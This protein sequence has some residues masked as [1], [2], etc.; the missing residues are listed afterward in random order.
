MADGVIQIKNTDG[1]PLADL[2]VALGL[3]DEDGRV[4]LDWFTDP[5]GHTR[6]VFDTQARREALERALK[7]LMGLATGVIDEAVGALQLPRLGEGEDA[8]DLGVSL[9]V[10]GSTEGGVAG[11]DIGL[12]GAWDIP[13]A[14]STPRA[15][16]DVFVRLIRVQPDGISAEA[17]VSLTATL[18]LPADAPLGGIGLAAMITDEGAAEASLRFIDVEVAQGETRTVE[19]TF[20]AQTN[21]QS[22]ERSLIELALAFVQALIHKLEIPALAV[23]SDHLFQLLGWAEPGVGFGPRLPALDLEDLFTDPLA[24]FQRWLTAV[25][26]AGEDSLKALLKHLC[27]LLLANTG[28][29]VVER[30]GDRIVAYLASMTS[31]RVELVLWTVTDP[32][33][34]QYLHVGLRAL[35]REQL[36]GQRRLDFV[37]SLDVFRIHLTGAPQI[38]PVGALEVA[39]ALTPVASD[40]K[41][42]HLTAADIEGEALDFLAPIDIRAARAGFG[43]TPDGVFRPFVEL[44]GVAVGTR[45]WERLDLTNLDAVIEAAGDAASELVAQAI[46]QALGM[47]EDG[48]SWASEAGRH[49]AVLL[50]LIDPVGQ[51]GFPEIGLAPLLGDPVGG[52]RRFIAD[53]IADRQDPADPRWFGTWLAELRLLINALAGDA[54][55]LAAITGDGQEAT[56][57]RLTLVSGT[58]ATFSLCAWVHPHADGRRALNLELCLDP[59]PIVLSPSTKTL[60]TLLVVG[61]L[62]LTAPATPGGP[63]DV[64]PLQGARVD[65]RLGETLQIT[66]LPNLVAVRALRITAGATW[67]R[68]DDPVPSLK[69]IN[70]EIVALGGLSG[71]DLSIP[72]LPA[73]DLAGLDFKLPDLGALHLPLFKLLFRL[74]GLSLPGWGSGDGS[75]WGSCGMGLAQLLVGWPHLNL[76]QGS[77]LN[78]SVDWPTL[79][80]PAIDWPDIDLSLDD[81]RLFLRNPFEGLLA[82][83]GRLFL[84][85]RVGPLQLPGLSFLWRWLRGVFPNA[86]GALPS[87]ALPPVYGDGTY[88]RPWAIRVTDDQALADGA[89]RPIELLVWID[90]DGPSLTG[91]TN[92]L[93]ALIPSN[94]LQQAGDQG[95][96]ALHRA[97]VAVG[98]YIPQLADATRGLSATAFAQAIGAIEAL[99]SQGATLA[100]ARAAAEGLRLLQRLLPEIDTN[101]AADAVIG[102]LRSLRA[103][104]DAQVT[105]G[106]LEAGAVA[107]QA[108]AVVSALSGASLSAWLIGQLR[109]RLAAWVSALVPG[110]SR[111]APTHLG[112]GLRTALSSAAATPIGQV[113]LDM[114]ARFDLCSV[115]LPGAPNTPPEHP[116][117][118]VHVTGAVRRVD[119]WLLGDAAS[120]TR[121]HWL[122]AGLSWPLGQDAKLDLVL[123]DAAFDG[124]R[125]ARARFA[126]PITGPVLDALRT[127]DAA[128][129]GETSP[130]RPLWEALRALG[131][132]AFDEATRRYRLLTEPLALLLGGDAAAAAAYLRDRLWDAAANAPRIDLFGELLTRLGF[133][134]F[135]PGFTLPNSEQSGGLV[136]TRAGWWLALGDAAR[137]LV[138]DRDGTVRIVGGSQGAVFQIAAAYNLFTKTGSI[139][140]QF[141]PGGLDVTLRI[142]WNTAT[143]F[144][145]SLTPTPGTTAADVLDG[146]LTLA[147]L[148]EAE[149]DA[150]GERLL[151]IIA[152]LATEVIVGR[153]LSEH[154]IAELSADVKDAL[155]DLQITRPDNHARLMPLWPIFDDPG[156]FLLGKLHHLAGTITPVPGVEV[157]AGNGRIAVRTAAATGLA[158]AD[159]RLYFEV[160][161]RPLD[162]FVPDAVISLYV[163][164]DADNDGAVDLR[165]MVWARIDPSGV[166]LKVAFPTSAPAS[167]ATIPGG[168]TT[169]QLLPTLA[170]FAEAIQALIE[171]G[172]QQLVPLLVEELLKVLEGA[173]AD[174]TTVAS[175]LRSLLNAPL[176]LDA[177]ARRAAIQAALAQLV[178]FIENPTAAFFTSRVA[179]LTSAL[180]NVLGVI[181]GVSV[182]GANLKEITFTGVPIKLEVGQGP[183]GFGV[184]LSP[185]A[186]T[187]AAWGSPVFPTTLAGASSRV[188]V[189]LTDNAGHLQINAELALY[190]GVDLPTLTNQIIPFTPVAGFTVDMSGAVTL[191]I[192][193]ARD[194]QDPDLY[195]DLI[196]GPNL[197]V[198]SSGGDATLVGD[199]FRHYILPLIAGLLAQLGSPLSSLQFGTVSL[200]DVLAG[201]GLLKSDGSPE[202]LANIAALSPLRALVGAGVA[203]AGGVIEYVGSWQNSGEA[204]TRHGVIVPPLGAIALNTTGDPVVS[205]LIG[206]E[207]LDDPGQRVSLAATQGNDVAFAPGLQLRGLGL[208][209]SGAGSRPFLDTDIIKIGAASLGLDLDVLY[210]PFANNVSVQVQ[211]GAFVDFEDLQLPLGAAGGGNSDPI[212]SSLLANDGENPGLRVSVG[213]RDGN[214][215]LDFGG[216]QQLCLN[217]DAQFGPLALDTLCLGYT[218]GNSPT[219]HGAVSITLDGTFGMAGLVVA[220]DDFGLV[221]PVDT[222]SD[223]STWSLTISGLSVSYNQGGVEITGALLKEG[224]GQNVEYRGAAAIRAFGYEIA[225]VGAY[226]QVGDDPSLF[227]FCY[228]GIPL[229]GPPFFFVEGLAGGF[230]YNRGFERPE[231]DEV[232]DNILLSIMKQGA[233][234]SLMTQ[235]RNISKDYPAKRGAYWLAAGVK[236]N[237]FVFIK[238]R[239]LLYIL[240][241]NGFELGLLGLAELK[242]PDASAAVVSVTLALSCGFTT[243]NNNPMLWADAALTDG[244]YLLHK[245]CRLTGGFALRVWFKT[246]ECMLSIGGYNP[247]FIKPEEYPDVDRLGFRMDLFG[248]IVIKGEAY[249]TITPRE[250]MAGGKL[251]ATGK[252]GPVKAWFKAGLDVLIGWDPFYYFIDLYIS[253]GFEVDLWLFSVSMSIGVDLSL[254]G[255][256]LGGKARVDL[257]IVSFT[258]RFGAGEP[259]K[260]PV[261]PLKFA[262]SH[263]KLAEAVEHNGYVNAIGNFDFTVEAGQVPPPSSG[264]EPTHNDDAPPEVHP[265]ALFRLRVRMPINK[266]LGNRVPD[267]D[268]IEDDGWWDP[269]YEGREAAYLEEIDILPSRLAQVRSNLTRFEVRGPDGTFTPEVLPRRSPLPKAMFAADPDFQPDTS[270]PGTTVMLVDQLV[271][272]GDVTL[273]SLGGPGGHLATGIEPQRADFAHRLP[274]SLGGQW[275]DLAPLVQKVD[276]LTHTLAG[277]FR[278]IDRR[279]FDATVAGL[280]LARERLGKTKLPIEDPTAVAARKLPPIRVDVATPQRTPRTRYT[281]S[282]TARALLVPAQGALSMTASLTE[283]STLKVAA[284][285]G[286]KVVDAGVRSKRSMALVGVDL[287]TR[288]PAMTSARVAGGAVRSLVDRKRT[289]ALERSA[290]ELLGTRLRGKDPDFKD[291]SQLMAGTVQAFEFAGRGIPRE[292]LVPTTGLRLAGDQAT[293]LLFLGFDGRPIADREFAPGEHQVEVPR[294]AFRVLSFGMGAP[295][296]TMR[297]PKPDLLR[298][299]EPVPENI[300]P[301]IR[302][303]IPTPEVNVNIPRVTLTPNLRPTVLRPVTPSVRPTPEVRPVTPATPVNVR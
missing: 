28:D 282:I 38:D 191:R 31:P 11:L 99:A 154:F 45:T 12:A 21:E 175:A 80:W 221:I 163:P 278:P 62:R 117:P 301:D 148:T 217:L 274:L 178:A 126:D 155:A 35:A 151:G 115:P 98:Q 227:I 30:D 4:I 60:D 1:E 232:E 169:V 166:T 170:G 42:V 226:T 260:P 216:E 127:V 207:D 279:Y 185:T 276:A 247:H 295:L 16:I 7:G 46:R 183:N 8:I 72:N 231:I 20:D 288:A 86:G 293:R 298:E 223:P 222:V 81:L 235:L 229:G 257:A 184:W 152:R 268:N 138:I 128:V 93:L 120:P 236:F 10:R 68:G 51:P 110:G 33:G 65:A 192:D 285:R 225:A 273:A 49:L 219:N 209:F 291:G 303:R 75:A 296:G 9:V 202:S 168:I 56:P 297:A 129:M 116:T 64:K 252:W 220:A 214:F 5:I 190:L 265:E 112:F 246:G 131:L 111:G 114:R 287:L 302:E 213:V 130:A 74:L 292:G 41:I 144:G 109:S 29:V 289:S 173:G 210:D 124:V 271:L 156:A 284:A 182:S 181:N 266:I 26:D 88:E 263:L 243:R 27:K 36:D 44:Q 270:T 200:K 25:R 106:A 141:T 108:S 2:A 95:L 97:I 104:I 195:L 55:Y 63:I 39:G 15:D 164:I 277:A 159:A 174:A 121:L 125:L 172:V 32:T 299:A 135:A 242:L 149:R 206:R 261:P 85:L 215:H 237:S 199:V 208:R 103:T 203:I 188:G 77:G 157:V 244:S 250:A 180:A 17:D 245:D 218:P 255:P 147:P 212:G 61:L 254:W 294:G 249:F 53:L 90:P 264:A 239:A 19:F 248:A 57:W 286:A 94:L 22:L 73:I 43:L 272:A 37:A 300:R 290:L 76:G 71:V 58:D 165:L 82:R 118:A 24:A 54:N 196:P 177:A 197:V 275:S 79:S 69:V 153:L 67:E 89:V 187:A 139:E 253:V 123:H 241:D 204:F 34:T 194:I 262:Q 96:A 179:A 186:A 259:P 256:E 132:A 161:V 91:L 84:D 18:V 160:G 59:A 3:L 50:G 101:A 240:L 176:A 105:A 78:L 238:G 224:S 119:G 52:Y 102:A 234:Q 6:E 92:Q 13:D 134:A 171:A 230:G 40:G 280:M 167:L 107:S 145:A 146:P 193:F 66:V 113:A 23:I 283:T 70:P 150:L 142:T 48:N 269:T 158:L 211:V 140:V 189:F 233:G 258:V 198:T 228:L 83:L 47:A 137:R 14:T 87:L 162:G 205:A 267:D 201:A 100:R 281:P 143:G 251:E 133:A 122:E 136:L